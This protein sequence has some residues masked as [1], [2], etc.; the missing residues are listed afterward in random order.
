[1][2]DSSVGNSYQVPWWKQFPLETRSLGLK[3]EGM[4]GFPGGSVVKNLVANARSKDS[5]LG[6]ERS[7]RPQSN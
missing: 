6:L 1:M 4:W 7:H 3:T 2:M 5:L